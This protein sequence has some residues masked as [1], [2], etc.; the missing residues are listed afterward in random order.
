MLIVQ[1]GTYVVMQKLHMLA[2]R[3]MLKHIH[4][5]QLQEKPDHSKIN[6]HVVHAVLKRSGVDMDLDEVRHLSHNIDW[7]DP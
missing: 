6:L 1:A 2:F 7:G 5:C 3:Q 4:S